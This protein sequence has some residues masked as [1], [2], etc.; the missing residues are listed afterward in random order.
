[1][2]SKD[3]IKN[4]NSIKVFYSFL[5]YYMV[6]FYS[7][8]TLKFHLGRIDHVKIE[9]KE[10]YSKQKYDQIRLNKIGETDKPY[11]K[12]LEDKK[13]DPYQVYKKIGEDPNAIRIKKPKDFEHKIG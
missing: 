12:F 5:F 7:L 8:L 1:M 10:D 11:Y 4:F 6:F 9:W 13:K 3:E 2:V